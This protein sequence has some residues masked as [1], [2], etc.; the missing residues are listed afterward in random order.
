MEQEHPR[1]ELL[2]SKTEWPTEFFPVRPMSANLSWTLTD[3]LP[4]Y[5]MEL[6]NYLQTN[7][8]TGRL[9]WSKPINEGSDHSPKWKIEVSRQ[10]PPTIQHS[11]I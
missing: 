3:L 8:G 7:G 5:R 2:L 1:L 6:N 10:L 11:H 4:D 9:S